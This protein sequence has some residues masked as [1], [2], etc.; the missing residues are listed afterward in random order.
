MNFRIELSHT[1]KKQFKK[2]FKRY[3]SLKTDIADLGTELKQNPQLGTPIGKNCYKIRLS[4]SSKAKGKSGGARVITHIQ[5]VGETIYLLSIYDK[6]E[7][8]NL[9]D[10][11]IDQLLSEIQS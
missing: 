10:G 1:F 7:K 4:I 2:L 6:S 8:D 9:D 5:I 11:E 3:K